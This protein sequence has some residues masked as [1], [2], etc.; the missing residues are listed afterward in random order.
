VVST[1]IPIHKAV[2]H[3]QAALQVH[4][5]APAPGVLALGAHNCGGPAMAM[6]TFYLYG[7]DADSVVRRDAAKWQEWMG[8]HFPMPKM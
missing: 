5:E 4:L 2:K 7:N 6:I 8:E 3:E 1:V